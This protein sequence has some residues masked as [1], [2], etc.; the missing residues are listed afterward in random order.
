MAGG[1]R[2]ENARLAQQNQALRDK[3]AWFREQLSLARTGALGRALADR[4]QLKRQVVA[5]QREAAGLAQRLETMTALLGDAVQRLDTVAARSDPAAATLDG[6]TLFQLAEAFRSCGELEMA[7]E[8]LRRC[9]RGLSEQLR[10]SVSPDGVIPGPD[11]LIIGSPRAASTWLRRLLGLHPQ[12]FLL[13]EEPHY[14]EDPT[15]PLADYLA[16]FA[17]PAQL[18]QGRDPGAAEPG[19]RLFGEKSPRYAAMP[20]ANVAL[21]AALY[22]KLRLICTVREPVARAWSEIRMSGLEAQVL[23]EDVLSGAR[24]CEAL[25]TVIRHGRYLENLTRW[26]RHFRPEQILLLDFDQLRDDPAAAAAAAFEHIGAPPF[27]IA[28]RHLSLPG[29]AREPS[30]PPGRLARHLAEAYAGQPWDAASLRSALKPD[31][32]SWRHDPYLPR[33]AAGGGPRAEERVVEGAGQR[34]S[35][36]A[37]EAGH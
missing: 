19:R 26:A 10:R 28:P 22:P 34:H 36:A 31:S 12:L 32:R 15:T 27:E 11:F 5:T 20:E 29:G 37:A 33:E 7:A 14:F 3:L 23:D 35:P 30:A 2:R 13:A 8:C 25:E 21:L 6:R 24:R 4:K 18:F 1:V 9:G 17:A 16:S